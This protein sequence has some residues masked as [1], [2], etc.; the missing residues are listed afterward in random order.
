MDPYAVPGQRR[1]SRK[2]WIVGCT[3]IVLFCGFL[4]FIFWITIFS[5]T[6]AKMLGTET[7]PL[8][9]D[10]QRFD[11][12]AELPNIRKRV[13]SGAILRK[14]EVSYV[15]SD[16]TMDLMATYKPAP[17][18]EYDFLLPTKPSSGDVPP[19]G[20]GH[21][22][23]DVWLEDVTVKVY[24]PGQVRFVMKTSGGSTSKY[25]YRN[26][27]M[28]IDRGRPRMQASHPDIGDPNLSLKSI[29][30][31]AIQIGANKDAVATIEYEEGGYRFAI[32]GWKE[33]LDLDPKG[34]VK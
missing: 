25:Q 34:A 32:T 19:V 6:C 11:P 27:G 16:G 21:A 24:Q 15:R 31:K 2:G 3:G 23:N 7:Y 18:V 4:G 28:D 9:G 33:R 22:E 5:N 10:P 20:A 14:I 12:F 17:T 8:V 1:S 30:E 26:E 13:G 29:W